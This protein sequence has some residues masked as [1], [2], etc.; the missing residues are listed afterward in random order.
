MSGARGKSQ[1]IFYL[2]YVTKTMRSIM[3]VGSNEIVGDLE[4]RDIK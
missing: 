1:K 3:R 2:Q 4:G